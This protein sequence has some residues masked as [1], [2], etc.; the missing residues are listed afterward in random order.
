M[1]DMD[2]GP[3]SQVIHTG[4]IAQ[5]VEK[6]AKETGFAFDGVNVPENEDQ[7]YSV[8]Y[9]QFVV[10]LVK[11]VQEQQRQIEDLKAENKEL[12]AKNAVFEERLIALESKH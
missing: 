7:N 9:S 2:Y 5:E 8:A 4:F 12:E 10:P 6:A 1:K 3:S 11:A